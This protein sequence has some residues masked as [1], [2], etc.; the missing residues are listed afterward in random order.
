MFHLFIKMHF[1]IDPGDGH[2]GHVAAEDIREHHHGLAVDTVDDLTGDTPEGD[3]VEP[4]TGQEEA[5]RT[6]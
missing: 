2:H 3:M 1:Q 4:V 5:L 6:Y